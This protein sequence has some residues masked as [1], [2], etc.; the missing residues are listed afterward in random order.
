[1]GWV[2]LALVA[3]LLLGACEVAD[4]EPATIVPS[5]WGDGLRPRFADVPYLPDAL[6]G[7]PGVLTPD[8]PC[9]GSQTLDIYPATLGG[10]LGTLV[11]VHGGGF[12]GGD[13]Y[14][15]AFLGPIRRL[16]HLGWSVVSVNYR[17]ANRPEG[18]FPAGAHDVAAALRWV[19]VNGASYDLDTR[20]LVVGG[21]SAGGTLAALAGTTGN[22]ASPTFTAVPPLSGWISIAGI[23]D[24][25]TGDLSRFWASRW[26]ASPQQAT[27]ASA[28]TWWD[29]ED[30]RGW[31]VHGDLDDTVEYANTTRLLTRT[32]RSSRVM[33]DTVD[34]FAGGQP[35]PAAAR[36]HGSVLGMHADALEAWLGQLPTLESQANPVGSLDVG[37]QLEPGTV[38]MAGWALDPDT[39]SVVTVDLSVDGVTVASTPAD[40]RRSDVGGVYPL[41]GPDHGFDA[42]LTGVAPG[43][44]LVCATA[45]NVGLGTAD[46]TLGCRTVTVTA[47][48]GPSAP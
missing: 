32:N 28:V 2:A 27:A 39:P 9:G 42:T 7:C 48:A 44:R 41:H 35:Q 45:R 4:P 20:R 46:T 26:L 16:T 18:Q 24:F 22:A 40:R 33:R 3:G 37:R 19:R 47:A 5:D 17:L 25:D 12:T 14:P 31:L 8:D 38:R 11:W 30:P 21:F 1:M 10:Q 13:K 6:T 36:G 29:A 43:Q 34:R 15:L 23:L